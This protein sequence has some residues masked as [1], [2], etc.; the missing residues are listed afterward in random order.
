MSIGQAYSQILTPSEQQALRFSCDRL[1]DSVF[2]DFHTI[3]KPVDV[4]KTLVGIYLPPR[5]LHSYSPLFYKQFAVCIITVAWKLAQPHHLPLSS[6]AEEL[7]AWTIIQE[8]KRCLEDDAEEEV[9][10]PLETF[11][12]LYFEDMDFEFFR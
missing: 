4:D 11:I 7:A 9:E 6:V 3:E 2:D 12:D 10:E 5:Y 1:I 8:A